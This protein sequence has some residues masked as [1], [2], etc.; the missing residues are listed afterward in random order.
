MKGMKNTEQHKQHGFML[1]L[2]CVLSFAAFLFAIDFSTADDD[3]ARGHPGGIVAR[4]VEGSPATPVRQ[5]S[6]PSPQPMRAILI[7]AIAAKMKAAHIDGSGAALPVKAAAVFLPRAGSAV[8]AQKFQH[9]TIL[10]R[11]FGS[12]RAPPKSA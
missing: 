1:F 7:E 10:Q 9:L 6:T 12:A 5:Q 8:A 3:P 11:H 2:A 4:Q